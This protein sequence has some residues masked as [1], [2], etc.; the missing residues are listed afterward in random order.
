[1]EDSLK[2]ILITVTIVSMF[3]TAILNFIVIFPQEQGVSF[4][5][6]ESQTGYLVISSNTDLG[7]DDSLTDIYNSTNQGFDQW[8]VTQGFMGSNTVKQASSSG[9]KG[10]S[11]NIFTNLNTVAR[12]L[13]GSGSPV[14]LVINI[15]LGLTLS[16][17]IYATIQFVRQGR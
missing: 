13:F 9:I 6:P 10:Y 8:D 11:S 5:D 16:Y 12:Q 7:I 1:M 17:I 4:T 2:G 14:I 3:I 15:L